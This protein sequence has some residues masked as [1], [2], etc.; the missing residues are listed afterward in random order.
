MQQTATQGIKNLYKKLPFEAGICRFWYIPV[1]EVASVPALNPQ[2]QYS[3]DQ[4]ILLNSGSV[5][6]GPVAVPTS[7]L[8]FTESQERYSDLPFYQQK[9]V[10]NSPGNA[11]QQQVNIE[12]MAYGKYLVVAK[13]R[14]GGFYVLIG[15]PNSPA[16]FDAQFTTGNNA[17]AKHAIAFTAESIQKAIVLPSFDGDASGYIYPCDG[18]PSGVANDTEIIVFT[19]QTSQVINW[20]TTRLNRFGIFPTV[21]CYVQDSTGLYYKHLDQPYA[22]APPPSFTN[23]YYEFSGPTTGFIIIK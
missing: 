3:Y 2:T 23:L 8:G 11:P 21:E 20:N 1:N 6:R 16:D 13:L 14:A 4:P 19:S 18:V 7:T 12:N 5:W 15:T 22:D 9:I 17:E 10:G